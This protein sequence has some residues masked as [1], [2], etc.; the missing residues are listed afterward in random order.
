[1][2]LYAKT[3]GWEKPTSERYKGH[4]AR[5]YSVGSW[6]SG[7]R[8]EQTIAATKN[9]VL[10][11]YE[12]NCERPAG[13]LSAVGLRTRRQCLSSFYLNKRASVE[14]KVCSLASHLRALV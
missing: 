11:H 5:R 9:I 10:G 1:M 8:G 14:T 6:L 2:K 7:M 12:S 3:R 4:Q 13:V